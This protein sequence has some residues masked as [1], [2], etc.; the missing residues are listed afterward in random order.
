MGIIKE[1][2]QDEPMISSAPCRLDMGGTLDLSTFYLFLQNHLPCTFNAALDMRTHV[3][4][5]AHNN[6]NIL[7]SSKGFEPAEMPLTSA[8]FNHPVGL[9]LAVANHFQAE[10]VHIHIT[11]TSPPRSSLGGSSAATVALIWAFSKLLSRAGHAMPSQKEVALLAHA[12]EQ[13]IAGVVCGMQ[14]FLSAAFGGMNTWRWTG[15]PSGPS[16]S[17]QRFSLDQI[18]EFSKRILVAYCGRPHVSKD[19]N[20]TWIQ[21]FV[22]GRD[23]NA[24]EDISRLSNAFVTAIDNG[25]YAQALQA[26]NAETRLR[27]NL[28]PQVLDTVGKKLFTA[29]VDHDCGA[30]F[31]GAGGGGCIWALGE[32]EKQIESLAP[33]WLSI[34][35]QEEHA[36]L[37][38]T[39]IDAE[40]VL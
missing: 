5:E 27:V 34:L 15:E 16:F 38:D 8:P 4:L 33:E 1:C 39:G 40:G 6:D 17:R 31:T 30:R 10:G 37:L 20:R 7:V 21:G 22:G 26:M 13:S 32:T 11:S 28:T 25:D 36:G 2:L 29:A 35:N 18:K 3:S 23:R 24:W 14:D 19:I 9:I 12:I